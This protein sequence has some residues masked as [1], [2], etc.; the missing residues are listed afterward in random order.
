MASGHGGRYLARIYR[1]K[2]IQQKLKVNSK[3]IGCSDTSLAVYVDAVTFGGCLVTEAQVRALSSEPIP[4]PKSPGL[5][6]PQLVAVAKKLHVVLADR[7]GETLAD[8]RRYLSENRRIVAQLW[9]ADIG[10]PAVGHAIHIQALRARP[11]GIAGFE[12]LINDPLKKTAQWIQDD[13]VFRAMNRFGDMTGVPGK[14]TR[15]A[16][17]KKLKYVAYGAK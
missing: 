12:F 16:V 14:G 10:G 11:G 15:F 8:M 9:A 5:N 3:L 1:P 7:S 2:H 17:S 13:K 6:I 4:D